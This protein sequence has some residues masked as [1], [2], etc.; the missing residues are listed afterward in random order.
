[1][2]FFRKKKN[3]G[4]QQ[5]KAR[6]P[7]S[8]SVRAP[9]PDTS[10][11]SFVYS[12]SEK[13]EKSETSES[14][15]EGGDSWRGAC[16]DRIGCGEI[17]GICGDDDFEDLISIVESEGTSS[18]DEETV[19]SAVP[20]GTPVEGGCM[21]WFFGVVDDQSSCG[22]EAIDEGQIDIYA[23]S[24]KSSSLRLRRYSKV[25]RPEGPDHILVKVQVS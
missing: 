15:S 11:E 21:P 5:G 19:A 18:D 20:V 6:V 16:E 24:P 9:S 12:D 2:V 3:A 25:P 23:T 14:E 4:Q 17:G 1:M 7:F 8:S 13:S 22:S 10:E